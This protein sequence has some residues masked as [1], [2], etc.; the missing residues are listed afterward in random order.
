MTQA[1]PAGPKTWGRATTFV[2]PHEDTMRVPYQVYVD[3]DLYEREQQRLFQ[4]PTWNFLVLEAEI[5]NAGD[6][7]ATF[8]GDA[9]IVVVRKSDGAISAVVNRCA[10]KGAI[11]CFKLRGNIKEF[12]CVYHNW[13]YDLDGKLQGVAFR[14]GVGGKG[15]LSADFDQSK[16]NLQALRIETYRGLVFGTFSSETPKLAVLAHR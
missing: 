15:G 9:P 5:P 2:W 13:V 12:N 6:Y 3:P 14:R 1:S 10:H 7:K 8:V 16:H 11:L 4:G